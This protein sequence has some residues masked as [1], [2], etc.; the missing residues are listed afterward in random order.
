MNSWSRRGFLSSAVALP[1][2]AQRRKSVSLPG[3]RLSPLD[4]I[5]RQNLKI[6]NV[7]LISLGYRLKPEEEW[8]D[9]DNNSI[10]WKT[11]SVIVEISTDA[12]LR[13][14]GGCS[15]YN[16]PEEMKQYL[17]AIVRPILLGKNPFDVE[18]VSGGI[19]HRRGRGVWAGVDT[20]LWDI[21]GKATGLPLY[22]LLATDTKPVTRIPVYASGGEFTWRKNSRFPGPENLIKEALSYKAAGYTAFKFRMGGGFRRLG[23]TIQDYIPYLRALRKAVGPEFHLIQEANQRWT[24]EQCLEIAPVLEELK[25]LWFEEPTRK[26]IDDY[27]KIKRALPTVKIS[28][29][30]TVPNRSEIAEWIDRGAY[31]IIQPGCDD[32]GVTETW[33]M[34]RMGHTRGKLLCPH[35]W[36]DGLVT[37]ANA[38]LMAAVPNRFMLESNMTPN[39]FKEGLFKEPL[40]VKNGFYEVP[41]KPG[42]GVELKEGLEELYP[43]IP[44]PW[45]IPD[46]EMPKA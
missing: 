22:R 36:Q 18:S 44:G 20:A 29:G 41:E 42:L 45:N 28:G 13:G 12:G 46:P 32:G 4:G 6:T 14:I 2:A 23:I 1:A 40:T 34:A 39:P 9:G 17:E 38:H 31:D 25:I 43:P 10:I 16:G 27:L 30:E 7:R 33:H 3:S 8:P 35:N 15:R 37:V 21:I 24:V 26:N 11:E 5:L 19:A